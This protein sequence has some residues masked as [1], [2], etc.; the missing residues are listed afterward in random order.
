VIMVLQVSREAMAL[1]AP[2]PFLGL[3]PSRAEPIFPFMEVRGGVR[4]SS[5]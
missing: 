3:E 4:F 2:L 1:P 5:S